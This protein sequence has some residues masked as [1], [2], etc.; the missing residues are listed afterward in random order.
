[1]GH[2]KR[3]AIL[4]KVMD[5]IIRASVHVRDIKDAQLKKPS[6]RVGYTA[7]TGMRLTERGTTN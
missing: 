2:D 3:E 4:N 7:V 5:Q 6:V 1:M